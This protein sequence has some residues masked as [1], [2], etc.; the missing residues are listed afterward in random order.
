VGLGGRSGGVVSR[1]GRGAAGSLA[2]VSAGVLAV[3]SAGVLAAASGGLMTCENPEPA[4]ERP[5]P[6]A[7]GADPD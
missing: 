6:S 5:G 3:V 2:V 4:A 7:A 1:R